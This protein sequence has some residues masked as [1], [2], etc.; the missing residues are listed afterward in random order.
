MKKYQ[1]KH[2]VRLRRKQY[3][4]LGYLLLVLRGAMP[5]IAYLL[6]SKVLND[7]PLPG[8]SLQMPIELL[9]VS[10]VILLT[11]TFFVWYLS[12]VSFSKVQR[13]K[14]TLKGII[15]VNKFY[16]ENK[17][18]DKILNSMVFKFYWA[19]SN[20]YI[21]VYPNGASFTNKMN[22]LTNIF[23]TSLNL[24]VISVQS[25]FANH[26]TYVLTNTSNNFINSTNEWIV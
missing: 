15:E 6:I 22:E 13:I 23:Q 16:Y 25:D 14:N 3:D 5:L 8:L 10:I 12:P 24:T 7:F 21:E 20:L 26:T 11:N 4:T 2:T 1:F 17:D 9:F 19:D 18:L